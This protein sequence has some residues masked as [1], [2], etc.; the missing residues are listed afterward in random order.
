MVLHVFAALLVMQLP[1][2]APSP[3]VLERFL[4]PEETPLVAYQAIRTMTASTRGGKMRA[5]MEVQTAFDPANGFTFT[6]LSES[7]SSIIRRRV[8]MAA[9]VAEQKAVERAARDETALTP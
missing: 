5:E 6:V 3:E 7:G 9:L 2:A 1:A 4:A 8:M